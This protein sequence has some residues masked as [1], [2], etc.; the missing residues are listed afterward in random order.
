MKNKL[1][2]E[3][4]EILE[5]LKKLWNEYPEQRLGQL[6]EN[7]VF[8]SGQRGD[9]TSV[10]LFHQQDND[11]KNFIII[12]IMRLGDERLKKAFCRWRDGLDIGKD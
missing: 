12:E 1:S 11:T 4:E 10:R 6:L 8:F 5:L 9:E 2:K 7:Y 3:Q